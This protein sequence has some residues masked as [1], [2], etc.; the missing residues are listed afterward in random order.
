VLNA[1]PQAGNTYQ[2][3]QD[4][5]PLA[6]ITGTIYPVRTTGNYTVQ[7]TTSQGCSERS[8]VVPVTV[9]P[10]PNPTITRIG[11]TLSTDPNFAVYQWY[12]NNTAIPGATQNTYTATQDGGYRVDVADFNG[13]DSTSATTVIVFLGVSASP[14]IEAQ[15]VVYPNPTQD[16]LTIDGGTLMLKDVSIIN[17][18]GVKVYQQEMS[19]QTK[20]TLAL[21]A[22]AAGMYYVRIQ[23]G[24]DVVI[25]KIEVLK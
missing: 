8:A 14:A 4:G 24:A 18:T 19:P 6:G 10:S 9:H 23:V 21:G 17:S 20:T 11:N 15:I 3:Y 1:Y 7:V 13:C 2:W 5:S 12:R 25:R 16:N 22:L